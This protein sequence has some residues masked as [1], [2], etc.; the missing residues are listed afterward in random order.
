MKEITNLY[1]EPTTEC[2]LSCSICSRNHWTSETIGHMEHHTFER[3]ISN[4]PPSVERIVFSGVGEPMTHPNILSLIAQAK[5]TVCKVGLVTNGVLLDDTMANELLRLELDELW[6]SLDSVHEE[7]VSSLSGDMKNI[8]V[9]DN[10]LAF[11]K[12]RPGHYTSP[13]TTALG[14]AFIL[15]KSNLQQ[16]KH[17]LK[18]APHMG[19]DMIKATHLLPYDEA[20]L[21]EICY[22]RLLGMNLFQEQQAITTHVDLPL[23]ESSHLED[24]GILNQLISPTLSVSLF[25]VPIVRKKDTCKFVED[26]YI[27]VRWD[28]EVS[29]C[30]ALLHD[31]YAMQQ[32]VKRFNGSCSYGN[33][34][35]C[36]LQEIWDQREYQEFRKRVADFVFSPCTSCGP[37]DLFETN[38]AD[39]SGNIFPTC[40][41]CLWAQGLFQCP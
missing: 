3:I 16:F 33:V 38:E 15:M 11:A 8:N 7:E 14:I 39:C 21:S 2:N 35:D 17:L 26:G 19:I 12:K 30:V 6:V 41:A 9:Y 40:G 4:L 29:P 18:K 23:M 20:Q 34:K 10:V 25:D 13:K 32:G 36:S 27:F 28:G 1:I 31:H 24:K 37:C 5:A 22:E